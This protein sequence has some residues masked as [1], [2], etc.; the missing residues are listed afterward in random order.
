MPDGFG[1]RIL[2]RRDVLSDTVQK[3]RVYRR[4]FFYDVEYATTVEETSATVVTV[5][6]DFQTMQ[7]GEI[8]TIDS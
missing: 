7:G 1:A 3:A 2:Y 6:T 4:D 5:R 8:R